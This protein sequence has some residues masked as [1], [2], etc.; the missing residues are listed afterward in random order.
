MEVRA[1][2]RAYVCVCVCVCVCVYVCVCV[3]VCVYFLR[4]LF[5]TLQLVEKVCLK[6]VTNAISIVTFVLY[7]A[8]YSHC[9]CPYQTTALRLRTRDIF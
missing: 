1:C 6:N 7:F 2:V 3:C 8:S 4:N 9:H 5:E